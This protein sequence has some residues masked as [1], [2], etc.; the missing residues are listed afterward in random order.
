MPM[1]NYDIGNY[2]LEL[3]SAIGFYSGEESLDEELI[4][5][6]VEL[7]I[8]GN[9]RSIKRLINSLSLIKIFNNL[10]DDLDS[11]F[12]NDKNGATVMFAMV[13]LQTAHPEVYDLLSDYPDFQKWDEDIA[14]KITQGK[15]MLEEN[16]QSNFEQATKQGEDFDESWEKILFKICYLNPRARAKTT[17]ISRFLSV[18]I[19]EFGSKKDVLTEL[20][21]NALGQSAITSITSKE[22]PNVRP[23]KG[24]YKPHFNQGFDD[25]IQRKTEDISNSTKIMDLKIPDEPIQKLKKFVDILKNEYKAVDAVENPDAEIT[26]HYSGNITIKYK[27]KKLLVLDFGSMIRKK[28]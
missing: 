17:D 23:A 1:S 12:L 14:F 3:L 11:N 13:C 4:R 22:N 28:I 25:W 24:S 26:I 18:L 10:S 6:F 9:P 16:F 20:I 2:V 8:T 27:R 15:E 19:E 7:S 5:T 21:S